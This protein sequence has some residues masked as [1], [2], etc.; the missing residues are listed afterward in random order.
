MLHYMFMTRVLY[1]EVK[2][3]VVESEAGKAAKPVDV[4]LD[5]VST[6]SSMTPLDIFKETLG[7]FPAMFLALNADILH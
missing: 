2:G 5:S 4:V 6:F 7:Q 1:H 3:M